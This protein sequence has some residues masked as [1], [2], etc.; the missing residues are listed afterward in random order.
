MSSIF[1]L[2][3]R[4]TIIPKYWVLVRLLLLSVSM[5]CIACQPNQASKDQRTPKV[6]QKAQSE[7]LIPVEGI[8]A[9]LD[10]IRASIQGIAV[11]EAKEKAVLRALVTGI[12]VDIHVEDGNRVKKGQKLARL[13]RP[14]ANSLLAKAKVAL[15]QSKSEVKR[16]K[17]LVKKAV[18]SREELTRAKFQNEQNRLEVKRLRAEAIHEKITSPINGVVTQKQIYR[19]ENVSPG[20]FLFEVIDTS[21]IRIPLALP[22]QWSHKLKVGLKV[23]LK[24]RRGEILTN[25]ARISYVSPIIDAQTGTIKVFVIPPKQVSIRPGL[26]IKAEVILDEVKQTLVIPKKAI[27]YKNDQATVVRV[28]DGIARLVVIKVGY[29]QSNQVQ[30]LDKLSVGDAIVTFGQRGLA[31]GTRVKLSVIEPLSVEPL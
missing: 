3:S 29:E 11:V 26:Y 2:I 9:T 24:N 1:Y 5:Y 20:Q 7:R 23:I 19:G 21:Q 25:D 13:S 12:V 30:V 27:I 8:Y 31:D 4:H 15:Q 18:A 10:Q 16:L 14:G 28:I 22:E 6:D 17:Q